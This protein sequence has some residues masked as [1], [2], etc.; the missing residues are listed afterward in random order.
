MCV[1]CVKKKKLFASFPCTW[2]RNC[3]PNMV[4]VPVL[5]SPNKY[6][7][8]WFRFRLRNP[9]RNAYL[10]I[11]LCMFFSSANAKGRNF[12]TKSCSVTA[13]PHICN[14]NFFQY[15]SQQL[16]KVMCSAAAYPHFRNKL[17]TIKV[18]LLL[19]FYCA[20]R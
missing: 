2:N 3:I 8:D 19:H 12:L 10:H 20:Q 5:E 9:V 14:R 13:A 15:G 6:G 18:A 17:Q 11:Y 7:T 16:F 4:L 1:F